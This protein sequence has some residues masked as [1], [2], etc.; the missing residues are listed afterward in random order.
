[1]RNEGLGFGLRLGLWTET[2]K[3]GLPALW[4]SAIEFE[5]KG[6]PKETVVSI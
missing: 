4:T 3:L 5:E 1:L 2:E 6:Y